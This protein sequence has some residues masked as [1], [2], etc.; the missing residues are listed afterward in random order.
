MKLIYNNITDFNALIFM[1]II[2]VVDIET[3]LTLQNIA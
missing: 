2:L 1:N 3:I